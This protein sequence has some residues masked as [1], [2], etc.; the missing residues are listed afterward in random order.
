M[1]K[2]EHLN[3]KTIQYQTLKH[4]GGNSILSVSNGCVSFTKLMDGVE[5]TEGLD[6]QE[7]SLM[8][9][10]PTRAFDFLLTDTE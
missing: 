3:G 10:N 5:F 9:P 1:N 8:K 7:L 2:Y 4:G 6:E